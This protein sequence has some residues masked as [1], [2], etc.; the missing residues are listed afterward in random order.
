MLTL[1]QMSLHAAFPRNGG[2]WSRVPCH[3][4]PG[5]AARKVVSDLILSRQTQHTHKEALNEQADSVCDET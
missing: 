1:T 3:Q 4:V 5:D 2:G